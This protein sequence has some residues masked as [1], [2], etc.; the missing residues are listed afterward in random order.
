MPFF[1]DVKEFFGLGEA[2]TAESGLAEAG[3]KAAKGAMGG[4]D[5]GG[6]KSGQDLHDAVDSDIEVVRARQDL[7]MAEQQLA[8][9]KQTRNARKTELQN[10]LAAAKRASYAH[11]QRD[12]AKGQ[13]SPD[14]NQATITDCEIK[15]QVFPFNQ[16]SEDVK[17]AEKAVQR[18]KKKVA[19]ATTA[20]RSRLRQGAR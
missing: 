7:Q 17:Q 10:K 11:K 6:G 15:L 2:E 5:H 16:Y 4:G 1:D 3:E 12:S 9:A 19:T 18:M 14:P 13:E 8:A 20:A